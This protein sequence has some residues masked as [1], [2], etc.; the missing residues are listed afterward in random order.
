MTRIRPAVI[1]ALPLVL[2]A[3][4]RDA[5]RRTVQDP[6]F[7]SAIDTV[8]TPIADQDVDEFRAWWDA[9]ARPRAAVIRQIGRVEPK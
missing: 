8:E 5:T 9:D 7:R 6:E 1:V 2:S 3:A 4:L